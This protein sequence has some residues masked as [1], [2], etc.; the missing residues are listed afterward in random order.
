MVMF[1]FSIPSMIDLIKTGAKTQTTRIPRKPRSNGKPAYSIGEKV[2]LYYKPRHKQDCGN[3]IVQPCPHQKEK[4]TMLSEL[5]ITNCSEWS[6][7]FGESEIIDI[8]HYH[9]GDYKER[10]HE[11]WM[12]YS[13]AVAGKEDMDAW[14]ISDGFPNGFLQAHDWFKAT[15]GDPSWADQNLDVIVW[16]KEPIVKRW[17]K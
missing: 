7:F 17:Q 6:N 4:D 14:A 13:L 12:G 1:G 2:Q 16:Q 9:R 3:C 15:T 10:Y 5:S 11:V 8:I